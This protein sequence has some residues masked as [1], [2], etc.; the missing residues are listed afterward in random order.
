MKR[1]ILLVEDNED[2]VLLTLRA[3]KKNGITTEVV[4][5]HDGISALDYLFDAESALPWIILLDLKLPRIDGLETLSS[6]RSH[7]RTRLVPVIILSSSNEKGDIIQS[8]TLGANS[9]LRK[10]GD[11]RTF[12]R[13][14]HTIHTY[15]QAN[16]T[17]SNAVSV[18]FSYT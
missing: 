1:P 11:F 5:M 4:V 8:Y 9:Y 12:E 16:E 7:E 14:V 18:P 15:W 6:L 2:D 3:M 13:L 17:A 10:P